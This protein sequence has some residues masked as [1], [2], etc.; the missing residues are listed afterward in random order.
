M[1]GLTCLSTP[2]L[3]GARFAYIRDRFQRMAA[4]SRES[5]LTIFWSMP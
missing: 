3:R 2:A 1:R 4:C 5:T